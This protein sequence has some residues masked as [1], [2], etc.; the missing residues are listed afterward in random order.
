MEKKLAE[1]LH[2]AFET[3]P[4][5]NNLFL[6]CGVDVY[7]EEP[8]EIL[9]KLPVTDKETIK[10]IG[11]PNFVD[12]KYL[13]E[14]YEL[15]RDNTIHISQTSGTTG[16][17]MH[18][19]WNNKEYYRSVREHW[20]LRNQIAGI[21]PID[22]CCSVSHKR[23][24]RG[25]FEITPYMLK[26]KVHFVTYTHT[27]EFL[28]QWVCFSPAW[29]YM[30]ASVLSYLVNVAR[31]EGIDIRESV[32]YIE[33]AEE[34]VLEQYRANVETY[35]GLKA[36]D[37][38]GCEETNGIAMQC[39]C[40]QY[41]LMRGNVYAEVYK[42]GIFSR[43]GDGNMCLTGLHNTAMPFIRYKLNDHVTVRE[44]QCSCGN[45]APTVEIHTNRF[46]VCME[47][48][49]ENSALLYPE[50]WFEKPDA[51]RTVYFRYRFSSE[52]SMFLFEQV[53]DRYDETE[54][55]T[56]KLMAMYGVDLSC[57]HFGVADEKCEKMLRGVLLPDI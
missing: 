15:I 37:M 25:S 49:S 55:Q 38:Y 57:I 50:A 4:Y 5:Y 41:H 52:G 43:F 39:C 33:F 27:V 29:V 2:T 12:G 28:K 23:S 6:N 8:L 54:A 48:R 46:P 22:R 47:F 7:Q 18:I 26:F 51:N 21:R 1:I 14:E 30:P 42:E 20:M 44:S 34:P 35:F 17:P 19:L 31:N 24:G 36:Y 16:E 13:D 10:A 40:G 53:G 9:A 32:R 45:A 3:V 56:R 11:W